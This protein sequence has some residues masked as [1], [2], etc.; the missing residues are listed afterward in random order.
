MRCIQ[1][2]PSRRGVQQTRPPSRSGWE[3]TLKYLPASNIMTEL[4]VS[5][6]NTVQGYRKNRTQ[7]PGRMGDW[8]KLSNY[9][10][11]LT[12]ETG[13][14]RKWKE[15]K[16]IASVLKR[17]GSL[18]GILEAHSTSLLCRLVLRVS[19]TMKWKRRISVVIKRKIAL[20]YKRLYLLAIG[21]SQRPRKI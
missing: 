11:V 8:R 15:D 21:P 10:K 17:E 13:Y 7:K 2:I 3:A 5:R 1:T 6:N 20:I 19:S 12:R 18:R 14:L 16:C 9:V 4:I